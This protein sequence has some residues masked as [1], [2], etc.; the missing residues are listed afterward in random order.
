[1]SK[2]PDAAYDL[3]E[4]MAYNNYQWPTE[5]MQQKK[6]TESIA[7]LTAQMAAMTKQ[8]EKLSTA[9]AKKVH[10]MRA[11]K[12]V[13]SDDILPLPRVKPPMIR[14]YSIYRRLRKHGL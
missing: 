1:M 14:A 2:T 5:R 9:L 12:A 13:S 4:E 11:K 6:E 7:L 8:M 3:L 10:L